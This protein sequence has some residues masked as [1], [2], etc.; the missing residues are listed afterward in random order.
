MTFYP[1]LHR[2]LE[3]LGRTA[4]SSSSFSSSEAKSRTMAIGAAIFLSTL[5]RDFREYNSASDG[6]VVL[7]AKLCSLAIMQLSDCLGSVICSAKT[8][9]TLTT[10]SSG[11]TSKLVKLPD[12]ILNW[13]QLNVPL[14]IEAKNENIGGTGIDFSTVS[15]SLHGAISCEGGNANSPTGITESS[16]VSG[17][18]AKESNFGKSSTAETISL[19]IRAQLTMDD[20]I[21]TYTSGMSSL[22]ESIFAILHLCYDFQPEAHKDDWQYDDVS[23]INIPTGKRKKRK[24]SNVMP[25]SGWSPSKETPSRKTF[26]RCALASDAL[27]TLRKCLGHFPELAGSSINEPSTIPILLRSLIRDSITS[28]LILDFLTLGHLLE[29]KLVFPRLYNVT[30]EYDCLERKGA[31]IDASMFET[32][33][34]FE[35]WERRL[36]SSHIKLALTIGRG[37]ASSDSRNDTSLLHDS[38]IRLVTFQGIISPDREMQIKQKSR[39]RKPKSEIQF[40]RWPLP[41]PSIQN[42]LISSTLSTILRHERKNDASFQAESILCSSVLNSIE[43][44]FHDFSLLPRLDLMTTALDSSTKQ[45]FVQLSDH[46][47]LSLRDARLFT[48][49]LG[50]LPKDEQTKLLERM[51]GILHNGLL[52]ANVTSR[53]LDAIG[54]NVE[55]S[56]FISRVVTL[57]ASVMDLISSPGLFGMIADEVDATY[58]GLPRIKRKEMAND[59]RC[60]VSKQGNFQSLF[61][62]WK[63]PALPVSEVLFSDVLPEPKLK[64]LEEV[65][66]EALTVGFKVSSQDGC[67]LLFTSWNV[68]GKFSSWTSLNWEGPASASTIKQS[69]PV[70]RILK[71]RDEMCEVH[72]L[73]DN[74]SIPA[75]PASLL[76]KR[77]QLK[78]SHC[79]P[80][81]AIIE[82]L[83]TSEHMLANLTVEINRHISRN[84]TPDLSVFAYYEA[85]PLY[86]SFLISMNTLPGSND[87]RSSYRFQKTRSR[88]KKAS[89][90]TDDD[91]AMENLLCQDSD[92]SDFHKDFE[93]HNTGMASRTNALSRLHNVCMKLGAAPCHPDWL[94][95]NC[96]MREGLSPPIAVDSADRALSS[97]AHFGTAVFKAYMRSVRRAL[98]TLDLVKSQDENSYASLLALKMIFSRK[99]TMSDDLFDFHVSTLC[100]IS[101]DSLNLLVRSISNDEDF[102]SGNTYCLNS[103]QRIRGTAANEGWQTASGEHRANGQWET[104]LAQTLQGSSIQIKAGKMMDTFVDDVDASEIITNS[105]MSICRWRRVL[106]SVVNAMVPTTALLRFGIND[107]KGR[108]PHPLSD[109]FRKNRFSRSTENC[110]GGSLRFST[111][112][113]VGI[114]I[115]KALSFLSCV[116]AHSANDSNMR[117]ATLAAAD[118]LLENSSQFRVM[119]SCWKIRI[120]GEV[121]ERVSVGLDN[122]NIIDSQK[123]SAYAILDVM[124]QHLS[125]TDTL[126]ES[127]T[128]DASE[129][130]ASGIKGNLCLLLAYLGMKSVKSG[131]LIGN[132]NDVDLIEVL[133][134]GC[135]SVGLYIENND[136]ISFFKKWGSIQTPAIKLLLNLLVQ[137]NAQLPTITRIIASRLINGLIEVEKNFVRKETHKY[138]E[139]IRTNF[140]AA[141]DNLS[142]DAILQ[143]VDDLCL[144]SNID[145][146]GKNELSE[147]IATFLGY[148]VSAHTSGEGCRTVLEELM[149]SMKTWMTSPS[150]HS[151]MKLACVL[152]SRFGALHQLGTDALFLTNDRISEEPELINLVRDYFKF[153]ASL[154]LCLTSANEPGTQGIPFTTATEKK[155]AFCKSPPTKSKN[156]ADFPRICSYVNTGE[157]F[158]EQHWYNC[159]TC[160]LLWDRGCCSLCVRVCH[161]GHDVGYSRKSSFFCDCGAES[162]SATEHNRPPCKCLSPLTNEKVLSLYKDE[163]EMDRDEKSQESDENNNLTHDVVDSF[164]RE[165]KLSIQ[166]LKES[167]KQSKW[168]EKIISV[169]KLCH[170]SEPR[171][172]INVDS[173]KSNVSPS[174]LTHQDAPNL[175]LRSSM[176]LKVGYMEST[177][178]LPV[179]AVRANAFK[180]PMM[181]EPPSHIRKPRPNPNLNSQLIAADDRGRL[182]ISECNSV[183][184]CTAIPPVNVRDFPR[185]SSAPHLSRSQINILGTDRVRFEILGMLICAENYRHMLV[186]GETNASVVIISKNFDSFDK[187]I[188]LNLKLSP[189]EC[190]GEY[191]LKCEWI[192]E[193]ELM[194][195]AVCGTVV[196]VFDLKRAESNSCKATTH[197]ALAYDD[198]LIRSAVMIG[199]LARDTN[200]EGKVNGTRTK[201]AILLDNGRLHFID[202]R[203]D[204]EGDLE[205]QGE[206]F[207]ECGAGLSFPSAG[208]CRYGGCSPMGK[209][210][211]I[212]SLGEGVLLTYLNQCNLLLYQCVSSCCVAMVLDSNGSICGTFEFLPSL[213]SSNELM[214][215]NDISGPYTHFEELGIVN[216]NGNSYYRVSCVGKSSRMNQSRLL[217]IDFNQKDT[218]ISELSWPLENSG[219]LELSNYGSYHFVGTSVFST[220]YLIN[221]TAGYVSDETRLFERAFLAVL[222][223]AGSILIF[224]EDC[225]I[226]QDQSTITQTQLHSSQLPNF[227]KSLQLTE[228]VASRRRSNIHIFEELINVSEVD[229]LIFGGDCVGKDPKAAKKNL[230]LNNNDFLVSPSRDGGTLTAS[231][232]TLASYDSTNDKQDTCVSGVTQ[233]NSLAIVAVRVLVGSMPESIPREI[234]VMGSGRSL[235]LKKKVKRWYD[236]LLSDE[237]IL[238]AIR[239]GLVSIWI[240]SCHDSTI[241]PIIDS[242][243]VYARSRDSAFLK[244]DLFSTGDNTILADLNLHKDKHFPSFYEPGN[245]QTLV[246]CLQALTFMTQFLNKE[247]LGAPFCESIRENMKNII[248]QTAL[249][250]SERGSLRSH[251]IALLTQIEVNPVERM[252][253][254]DEAILHG[255]M[256]SMQDLQHFIQTGLSK[257]SALSRNQETE[258]N[259]PVNV[260]SQILRTAISIAR[261]RGGNYRKSISRIIKSNLSKASLAVEAKNV[262]DS[263]MR[264]K[265][266]HE[267]DNSRFHEAGK[268][269]SE[270]ILIE[271]ACSDSTEYA[272]FDSLESLLMCSDQ[273]FVKGCCDCVMVALRSNDNGVGREHGG[274]HSPSNYVTY[275]CDSCKT[276]PIKGRRYTLGG[277]VDIDLC[278]ECFEIGISYAR[279][280]ELNDPLVIHGK[281]LL[282]DDEEMACEK[283]W[284]M[285]PKSIAP[286]IA[287]IEGTN[288]DT[289]LI[290]NGDVLNTHDLYDVDISSRTNDGCVEVLSTESF[291]S[292]IFVHL[293]E[294]A[295]RSINTVEYCD[296]PPLSCH[297]LQLLLDIAL[298]SDTEEMKITRGKQMA[299]SFSE[300][301]LGL[302]KLCQSVEPNISKQER[303]KLVLCIR[304][305]ASLLL[306]RHEVSTDPS[307]VSYVDEISCESPARK[308]KTDPRFVCEVHGLPAVRRRCSHGV[309]KDRRFYVCGL[310]RKHRCNYFK[311]SSD[312]PDEAPE[313]TDKPQQSL[314]I[315]R[316]V[317]VPLQLHMLKL[318]CEEKNGSS[319]QHEICKFV[320][321]LIE[322]K[323]GSTSSNFT[324]SNVSHKD[325]RKK[326][327]SLKTAEDESREKL[328]GVLRCKLKFGKLR[329][330]NGKRDSKSSVSFLIDAT[331]DT[332]LCSLLELLQV[333]ASGPRNKWSS[334][335]FSVLSEIISTD[336]SPTLRILAKRMLQKLCGGRRDVYHRVRDHY[337]FSFSY[338][339]LLHQSEA[340]LEA[341]I[342]VR[343]QAKQCGPSWKDEE[344]NFDNIS[345]AGL[346]G[347]EDLISE[348]FYTAEREESISSVLNE[349]LDATRARGHNWRQF[350][351]L[352]DIST[353]VSIGR[354]STPLAD[355]TRYGSLEQ[356]YQRPPI[357]SLVWLGSCLRGEN[358]VK[359]LT[360]A[361][362]A[363]SD[364]R[365]EI[366]KVTNDDID[367]ASGTDEDNMD[368]GG[369]IVKPW[370]H[371]A[372]PEKCLVQNLKVGDLLAFI[373]QFVVHGRSADLRSAACNVAFKIARELNEKSFLLGALVD[374]PFRNIGHLGVA[375]VNFL[376][377]INWL[378]ES[379]SSELDFSSVSTCLA[380]AFRNQI[381]T[382]IQYC[383]PKMTTNEA[384]NTCYEDLFFDLSNC[385]SCQ[386]Q[387]L[388]KKS[389]I[390]K[391][392]SQR[393]TAT[394]DNLDCSRLS[395]C[396]SVI[397]PEQ[398]RPY[399]KNRL[400]SCNVASASSEFSYY[401]QLKCRVALSQV[402][403]TVSDPRGRLVKSIGV[404]FTPRP[405]SD[406]NDL[407]NEK[408]AHLWQRC[409]TLSLARGAGEA[410]FKLK[411]PVVAANLRFTYEAFYEKLG[412]ARAP[413]G[414]IILHCPRCTRQVNN[415]HGVCGNCGEVAYQCRKCRHINYDALDAFLCVECGY[416][417]S[418]TFNYEVTVGIA[419]NA[420][421]ISNEEEFMRSMAMLRIANKRLSEIKNSLK[422]KILV[423]HPPFGTNH[424]SEDH[425]GMI[426]YGPCL[427]RSFLGGLPRNGSFDGDDECKLGN[428]SYSYGNISRARDL[429]TRIFAANRARS[430]ASLT[431]QMRS[432]SITLGSDNNRLS[433]GDLIVRQAFQNVGGAFGSNGQDVSDDVDENVFSSLT[434]GSRDPL[435]RLVANMHARTRISSSRGDMA[436]DDGKNSHNDGS[437]GNDVVG[438]SGAKAE[439]S[440]KNERT[441]ESIA[442]EC[443]KLHSQLREAQREC[444]EINRR[445]DSWSRLNK[446]ALVS[447]GQSPPFLHSPFSYT[448][449]SCSSCCYEVTLIILRC[450]IAVYLANISDSEHTVTK[451]LV[452]LL[453]QEHESME[454]PLLDLKRRA[455]IALAT[456][457]ERASTIILDELRLRLGAAQDITSAEILGKLIELDFPLVDEY[458]ELAVTT[459]QGVS[460]R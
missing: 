111:N 248:Q 333:M 399:Q 299:A 241:N 353:A 329:I 173:L 39:Q 392:A 191:L 116:S 292:H 37:N 323:Q 233:N 427:K 395:D 193:S 432:E 203:I 387:Q 227:S 277:T 316:N 406:V 302:M 188:D 434:S 289:T 262:L 250:P 201:L 63:S 171:S 443:K 94:D 328:D 314:A 56:G 263:C 95:A 19:F 7:D 311:W 9:G 391:N 341:A 278:K 182:I 215:Q 413:D 342:R 435:G 50:K 40:E 153:V 72:N 315:G 3:T 268:L 343:E 66:H 14:E 344:F 139:V 286:S 282:V 242:V 389:P 269:L 80:S 378:I 379:F 290:N 88:V 437:V 127:L 1:F 411:T 8:N 61:A 184:F 138:G 43:N 4:A 117:L 460:R 81:E 288:V 306:Q 91:D 67:H 44:I 71:L 17:F 296:S 32:A 270:L 100:Q 126:K 401:T 310:E 107:G 99:Y 362:I 384:I 415:A 85:L 181:S 213:T 187:I 417:S 5:S 11:V 225:N 128:N 336:S 350:C 198:V 104:L 407:K 20:H 293:V 273:N 130:C 351:C 96:R 404:Y 381:S 161:E 365:I 183:L 318:F 84:A 280:H 253:I 438:E 366:E 360:L 238:L 142:K 331:P 206:N 10:P 251:A 264:S 49:A 283:I 394:H 436:R 59:E 122:G 207:I 195:V 229:E 326:L 146:T 179:R 159:Y 346:L 141:L 224:G 444:F 129:T 305:L 453:F 216:K 15:G 24:G 228:N 214:G 62:D 23:S 136:D 452:K 266:C 185:T 180:I 428:S 58:Y 165:C 334:E 303:V 135:T 156:S 244:S 449:S 397:L 445:I 68:A 151:V 167:A 192:P 36:W 274:L 429:S 300:N 64:M 442:E 355:T 208:I 345:A 89:R 231:L 55:A 103:A 190:E 148:V 324:A 30:R 33:K 402:H 157:S 70:E 222:S 18:E 258:I 186:W 209:G 172:K 348:D 332:L 257:S 140:G 113:Q 235:K 237:E 223:S 301:I 90:Y 352:A 16:V 124:L 247:R 145:N 22:L 52:A 48:L 450:L 87:M 97:L 456:S 441:H 174:A 245:T 199:S 459:L 149:R 69:S 65:I 409:G 197:F 155:E 160:G 166:H 309:H 254:I 169:F 312:F 368:V 330:R 218:F 291:R 163:I 380:T 383:R 150:R 125:T 321:I 325:A 281:T 60:L 373:D 386:T 109:D 298:K 284:Q 319:L 200:T 377:L 440:K 398:I 236:F 154:D 34:I 454:R 458:I 338:R 382:V 260:L 433:R 41:L 6:I 426:L 422:K 21:V 219:G 205:D 416:C 175:S 86:V 255:L 74:G 447:V 47:V 390:P 27:N 101:C 364:V 102:T 370:N 285:S 45:G 363:L 294:V 446:D 78:R 196:H 234:M 408:F 144:S 327:Y 82:G 79:R 114:T 194:F 73:V 232:S 246:S 29:D 259:G 252:I 93:N 451:D 261:K 98:S 369:C 430:L 131:R 54:S 35:V 410:S 212:S 448:P 57:C 272:Q 164:P 168:D 143:L 106:F 375:S 457:S 424:Y 105:L 393:S 400:E 123:S 307:P 405:V 403:V 421:A 53:G 76:M 147:N 308:D 372:T 118:H 92:D 279:S 26:A 189:S 256:F 354:G 317:Q 265:S 38:S 230:S 25:G 439:E 239:N 217:V 418:G 178:L 110:E 425:E 83:G 271:I 388:A 420:V 108:K 240:S 335:W 46:F 162:S 297:V 158:S 177:P 77:I 419:L 115:M 75:A 313:S 295:S 152:A 51:I 337:V 2:T 385:V 396:N 356:I 423:S 204:E 170:R 340:I 119:E 210:S 134:K 211:T 414:S 121:I 339:K 267:K 220:P 112:N 12:D 31:I 455:I 276:L 176:P 287:E 221:S 120:L 347:V 374:G 358:Q 28:D 132:R 249:G 202:L 320:C 371:M 361:D 304:S 412:G 42:A 367:H 226:V 322:Q 137:G 359:V 275:Q 376:D 349:L 243:E 431:R 133:S 13:Y 357:V